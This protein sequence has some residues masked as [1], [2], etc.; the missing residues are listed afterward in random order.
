MCLHVIVKTYFLERAFKSL[1]HDVGVRSDPSL[2]PL[3]G[4]FI[5]K[6]IKRTAI[7]PIV[8]VTRKPHLHDPVIRAVSEPVM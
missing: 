7:A 6:M 3:G 2:S 1:L 4:S 8:G 5:K